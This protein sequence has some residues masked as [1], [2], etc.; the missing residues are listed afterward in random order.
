MLLKVE[1]R[2]KIAR[3]LNTRIN[4]PWV[5]ENME[6]PIFEHGVNLVDHALEDVLPDAF[7]VLLRDGSQG[8]DKAQARAFGERLLHA[9]NKKIDLP[10]LDEVQE[11]EF[12]KMVIS[13]L[14]E[15][16]ADGESIDNVLVGVKERVGDRLEGGAEP[17][18]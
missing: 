14:V 3:L 13:P 10:Y 2:K 8:I 16:M 12:I 9:I 1:E 15:A 11:A 18:G 7:G 4:I 17:T 5:P 6:G